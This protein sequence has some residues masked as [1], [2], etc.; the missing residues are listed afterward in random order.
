MLEK[1]KDREDASYIADPCLTL[2]P[3][4]FWPFCDLKSMLSTQL[5]GHKQVFQRELR[6][7]AW[8]LSTA[9]ALRYLILTGLS[10]LEPGV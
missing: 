8:R 3:G 1:L 10:C 5:L 6:P 2:R 9:S 4:L 7:G